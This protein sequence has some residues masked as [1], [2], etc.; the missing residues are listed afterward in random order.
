MKTN[1]T[2]YTLSSALLFM[3][4]TP[5]STAQVHILCR[6]NSEKDVV[7]NIEDRTIALN[8]KEEVVVT[9]NSFKKG[10]YTFNCLNSSFVFNM[11]GC[12]PDSSYALYGSTGRASL[13]KVI[14]RWQE[15]SEYSSFGVVYNG[16]SDTEISFD[17]GRID[18]AKG[19]KSN[20]S[21]LVSRLTGNAEL[22]TARGVIVNYNCVKTDKKF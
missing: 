3:I 10:E 7:V 16:V 1:F 19:L 18:E 11:G 8:S 5:S 6:L 9:L 12:A 22:K 13:Y 4:F 15:L 2:L 14:K 21:F 20:W 17:A